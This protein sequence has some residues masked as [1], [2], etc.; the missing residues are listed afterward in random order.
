MCAAPAATRPFPPALLSTGHTSARSCAHT[1]PQAICQLLTEVQA[2]FDAAVAVLQVGILPWRGILHQF[3]LRARHTE[4]AA[5]AV[6]CN[7]FC[8]A[9]RSRSSGR[10]PPSSPPLSWSASWWAESLSSCFF[11]G[12]GCWQLHL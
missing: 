7:P 9:S 12:H 11:L 1:R 6:H 2:Y 10:V 4:T 8:R 3:Q 5:M